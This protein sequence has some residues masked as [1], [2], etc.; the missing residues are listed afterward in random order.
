MSISES[1][2]ADRRTV[3]ATDRTIFAPNAPTSLGSNRSCVML[4]RTLCREPHRHRPRSGIRG[5]EVPPNE[6]AARTS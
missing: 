4:L 3:L 1:Y 6:I 2:S 5:L